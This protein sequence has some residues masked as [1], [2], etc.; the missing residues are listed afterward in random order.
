M[1]IIDAIGLSCPKP[2]LET[3]K[4]LDANSECME[5]QVLVDNKAAVENVSRFLLA[6]GFATDVV[7]N[8]NTYEIK[9]VKDSNLD[10]SS[11]DNE[12]DASDEVKTLILVTS[13][14][15]GSGDDLLGSRLMHNFIATLNEY[16]GL[17]K[18]VFL[19]G[20]VKLTVKGSDCVDD[21]KKF[22]DAGL[23]ILVCGTCLDHYNLLEDKLVGETTNMLDIVTSL[24]VADKVIAI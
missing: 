6:K 5:L 21:L 19:N 22:E 18:L 10:K 2:V 13:A 3:K 23:K 7:D 11:E 9:G 15:M 12:N 4:F 1:K 8:G 16:S 20:G 14:V 17:W 24:N